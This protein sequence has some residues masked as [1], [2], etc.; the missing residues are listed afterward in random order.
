LDE[1]IATRRGVMNAH[2][3]RAYPPGSWSAPGPLTNSEIAQDRCIM[4]PLYHDM[5]EPDQDRVV[6]A[7]RNAVSSH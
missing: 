4:L 3:E 5:T 1:G 6:D 7:L 2:R